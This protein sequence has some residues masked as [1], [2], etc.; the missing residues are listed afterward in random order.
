[1]NEHAKFK[2]EHVNI[3]EAIREYL[4]RCKQREGILREPYELDEK[5][6]QVL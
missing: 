4:K 1:M 3:S 5:L 2:S 6:G